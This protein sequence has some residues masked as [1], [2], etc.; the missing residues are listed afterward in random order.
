[1]TQNRDF[2]EYLKTRFQSNEHIIFAKWNETLPNT[3]GLRNIFTNSETVDESFDEL[4]RANTTDYAAIA[5][6]FNSYKDSNSRKEANV[7]RILHAVID[8]DGNPHVDDFNKMLEWLDSQKIKPAFMSESKNGY[9]III[10]IDLEVSEKDKVCQLLDNAKE[11][12][13]GVD[14]AL[15]PLSSMIRVPESYH[16]K[17]R[18]S[19]PAAPGFQLQTFPNTIPSVQD[20]ARN[21][22]IVRALEIKEVVYKEEIVKESPQFV[23]T[24]FTKILT[25]DDLLKEIAAL[26][27]VQKNGILFK[28]LAIFV[29]N[30]PKYVAQ[31]QLLVQMSQHPPDTLKD[32][33][34]N[35]NI[36]QVNYLEL[37]KWVSNNKIDSLASLIRQQLAQGDLLS[38]FNFFFV[39]NAQK[40]GAT[41][42]V[43]NK[44]GHIF[45]DAVSFGH[46]VKAMYYLLR[47][48]GMDLFR[49]YELSPLDDKGKMR[50]VVAKLK[51]LETIMLEKINECLIPIHGERFK[52]TDDVVFEKNNK[53]YL[54]TYQKASV[55]KKQ[56][57]K[58]EFSYPNID[59][60][61]RHICVDD[62]NY[63]WMKNWLA[64]IVQNPTI[65]LPTSV[66]L[67]GGQGSGKGVFYKL[68]IKYLFGEENVNQLSTDTFKRGWGDTFKNKLFVNFDEFTLKKGAD[69]EHIERLK[70]VTSETSITVSIKGQNSQK[71]DNYCH[72]LFTSNKNNPIPIQKD[73]RRYTIFDQRKPIPLEYVDAIDPHYHEEV[74]KKEIHNLY[75]DLMAIPVEYKDVVKALDNK[76]KQDNIESNLNTVETFLQ[77]MTNYDDFDSFYDDYDD[78][79][80]GFSK[81]ERAGL[82]LQGSM[83]YITVDKLYELYV[84]YCQKIK[85][86]TPM[87]RNNVGK[88]LTTQGCHSKRI[89]QY[90][91][92]HTCYPVDE[93]MELFEE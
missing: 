71:L 8:M 61:L 77:E 29:R 9:H 37:L 5:F 74:H 55:R 10:P 75:S 49:Y 1:M 40:A 39:V 72:F 60:V 32:W 70:S 82:I 88:E 4:C 90:N 80:V 21:T 34:E 31:A 92:K 24:F 93:L 26:K 89:V 17:D 48:D 79:I 67:K 46:V 53:T 27:S 65:K 13:E 7:S 33:A 54:N 15:K 47:N 56:L 11:I 50:T 63:Q 66:V 38:N 6:A 64:Y 16:Y 45:D 41:Y 23:D 3:N 58:S 91:K 68:I 73:D 22:E 81:D 57:I 35:K 19:D 51:I 30:Q 12:Y 84:V 14:L 76:T 87:L 42:K 83:Q 62:I 69:D 78:N 43:M 18:A 59:K 2:L 20:I 28:N 52:P 36:T 86:K 85:V 44:T 25:S